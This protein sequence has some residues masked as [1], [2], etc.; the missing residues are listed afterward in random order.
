MEGSGVTVDPTWVPSD[1]KTFDGRPW[2]EVPGGGG[3]TAREYL[4]TPTR[5]VI[6]HLYDHHGS[7]DMFIHEHAHSLDSIRDLHGIS[8]SR[9][10]SDLLASEPNSYDF[11]TTICGAYCT[12]NVEEGFAEYFAN[13]HGCQ[14]TR[15]QMEREVPR[16]AEFFFRFRSTRNLDN[17]WNPEKFMEENTVD[18]RSDRKGGFLGRLRRLFPGDGND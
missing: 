13:Y 4:K 8:N 7:A 6:N 16:I 5:V 11:L 14:E 12:D 10:W 1:L 2:S 17:I 9:V 18:E 3:S 15:A